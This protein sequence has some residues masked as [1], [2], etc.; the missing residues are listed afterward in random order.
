M[1]L[2]NLCIGVQCNTLCDLHARLSLEIDVK[3]SKPHDCDPTTDGE[4]LSSYIEK[5]V[6][7]GFEAYEERADDIT[8]LDQIDFCKVGGVNNRRTL[9][10][11]IL[12]AGWGYLSSYD[13]RFCN[14]GMH[15]FF[16][17][18]VWTCLFA[19]C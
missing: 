11:T 2:A 10:R 1:F 6:D 14:K 15:L 7:K 13:C 8:S 17:C 16:V 9:L 19:V 3:P 12:G 18:F 4:L 5:V